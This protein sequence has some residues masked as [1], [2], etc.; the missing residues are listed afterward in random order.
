MNSYKLRLAS[1]LIGFLGLCFAAILVLLP[2][3]AFLS[4]WG[5]TTIGPLL[6]WKSWKE[7][8]LASLI[9]VVA[10]VCWLRPEIARRMLASKLN[11]A[12]LAYVILTLAMTLLSSAST[13]AAIAG[14]LMNTRFLALFVLAEILVLSEAPWLQKLK[15]SAAAWLI[16]TGVL[17]STL[18][19]VQVSVLPKDFLTSF[20]YDKNTTIAPYVLVD[21]DPQA[22]R[23]F[24][25][26]RG[27]NT[28]AAYLLLPLAVALLAWW[29][30]RRHWLPAL[31]AIAMVFA[32]ILS[33]SRSAWLG[34]AAMLAVMAWLIIPHKKLWKWAKIG[35]I[36]IA[37]AGALVLWL[38]TTVPALRLA[39][40]H[41]G[42]N[43]QT[44]SLTEGSSDKHL[45]ATLDGLHTAF[46]HPLGLGVGAAGPA[47]FYNPSGGNIPE[48]YYVQIAEEVGLLGLALFLAINFHVGRRL[49]LQKDVLPRALLASFIG[50]AVINVFLH[51]WA[52]DP[53][54]MTWW[55]VAGLFI[56]KQK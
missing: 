53:T 3:H 56:V 4:T 33:G 55:A 26:M 49:W 21:Q 42:G 11:W 38:A 29:Q 1:I 46:T 31:A 41:S 36:P 10:V 25:T 15:K 44:E 35:A 7:I 40:F 37:V 9:P 45:Q 22:V 28:L 2:F 54:A 47:S 32:I 14:L 19:I 16:G 5:G 13:E 12:I 17:L 43:S 23:A 51:G 39:I 18:A 30:H 50:M 27:P 6:V 20:G 34:A 24:A 52:D 8:L 48:N